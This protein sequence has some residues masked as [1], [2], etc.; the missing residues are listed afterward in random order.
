VPAHPC[1]ATPHRGALDHEAAAARADRVLVTAHPSESV[2]STALRAGETVLQSYMDDLGAAGPQSCGT[3]DPPAPR[4]VPHDGGGID[5]DPLRRLF[6]RHL[7]ERLPD[8]PAGALRAAVTAAAV[9]AAL[10][11]VLAQWRADGARPD[12]AA[13]FVERLHAVAPLLP[14]DL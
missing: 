1:P 8:G 12:R 3:S 9:V 14:R 5:A 11:L 7:A 13:V 6:A 10:E 2:T 4:A